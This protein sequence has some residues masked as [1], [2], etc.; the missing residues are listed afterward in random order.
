MPFLG[1]WPKSR[2]AT[3]YVVDLINSFQLKTF[4]WFTE[5]FAYF[6]LWIPSMPVS[7][8]LTIYANGTGNVPLLLF[9][10]AWSAETHLRFRRIFAPSQV[11]N[12]PLIHSSKLCAASALAFRVPSRAF[13]L[14]SSDQTREI[15][16]SYCL[17]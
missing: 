13:T 16:I 6:T 12:E 1:V 10:A 3:S 5:D 2:L 9:P 7:I 11:S 17:G 8:P 15:L 14:C 4:T